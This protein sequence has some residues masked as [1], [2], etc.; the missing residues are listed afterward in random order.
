M[1]IK[2]DHSIIVSCDVTP[3]RLED[4]VRATAETPEVGAYK[5][6]FMLALSIGLSKS[7]DI[8]RKFSDKPVIYDHQ[9]AGTDIPSA[10]NKFARVCRDAGVD[11][12][13]IFP[14]SGPVT[15]EEWIDAAKSEK[16]EII[17]G[18]IMPHSSY[19]VSEGGY[20]ND[21]A[22]ERIYHTALDCGVES[23]MLPGTHPEIIT[24]A[25]DIIVNR[26]VDP[27]FFLTGLGSHGGDIQKAMGVSGRRWHAIIG[28]AIY[29]APDIAKAVADFVD[30]LR[31]SAASRSQI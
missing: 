9:K 4:L 24:K 29:D 3:S 19:L 2:R 21:D 26:N 25:K 27:V 16:I 12:V 8:I 23:F 7:V 22:V 15:Q 18:A 5:L 6:G 11:A 17:V 1:I 13:V 14:H 20:I 30:V 28:R 31:R 10:G